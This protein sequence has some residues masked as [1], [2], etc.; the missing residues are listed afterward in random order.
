MQADEEDASDEWIGSEPGCAIPGC[1][2]RGLGGNAE[3]RGG[4]SSDR[5]SLGKPSDNSAS[6]GIPSVVIEC[7]PVSKIL[8]VFT[9]VAGEIITVSDISVVLIG[10]EGGIITVSN[11]FVVFIGAGGRIITSSSTS[12]LYSYYS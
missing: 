12:L 5:G 7:I 6:L 1:E 11:I 9:G 3:D 8:V 10:A 2:I 4:D